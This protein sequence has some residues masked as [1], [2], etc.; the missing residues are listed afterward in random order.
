MTCNKDQRFVAVRTQE[1]A[2]GILDR[3]DNRIA[4]LGFDDEYRPVVARV[5]TDLRDGRDPEWY[6]W[7]LAHIFGTYEVI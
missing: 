2:Y 4:V 7:D 6:T 3:D 5:V 1:G